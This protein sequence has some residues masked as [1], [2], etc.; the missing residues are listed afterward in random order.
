VAVVIRRKGA[1]ERFALV[2]QRRCLEG[3]GE[4]WRDTHGID[5]FFNFPSQLGTNAGL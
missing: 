4:M 5:W 1:L 2:P 3:A